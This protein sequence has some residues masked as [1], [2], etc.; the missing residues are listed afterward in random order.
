MKSHAVK[1]LD[2]SPSQINIAWQRVK[3]KM[4]MFLSAKVV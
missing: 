1:Q 3:T 2:L 4:Q